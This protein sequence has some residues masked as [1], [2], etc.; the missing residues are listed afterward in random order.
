MTN[1]ETPCV[2]IIGGGICGSCA[3]NIL[4]G[5]NICSENNELT[6]GFI[7]HLFDQ[8][9]SGPGGRASQRHTKNENDEVM[10][11]DHGCQVRMFYPNTICLLVHF[12]Q[13]NNT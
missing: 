8:G 1:V 13:I 7:V 4:S 12:K 3:Y 6:K 2:A 9:R 5:S 11:W 10:K